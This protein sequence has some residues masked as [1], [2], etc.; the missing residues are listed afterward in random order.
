[1]DE[2]TALIAL[3]EVDMEIQRLERQL[4][5]LPQK[6][7]ILELRRKIKDIE[8]LSEKAA[9]YIEQADRVVKR[10]ED[11]TASLGARIAAEQEKATSGSVTD[12][13]ELTNIAREI[14][15]M[16]R[17]RAKKETEILE[18]LERVESGRAKAAEIDAALA[19]ARHREQQLISEFQAR[20][21]EL[22]HAIEDMRRKR[23][24]LASAI[25][26]ELLGRYEETRAAKH[27]IGLGVL[28]GTMCSVCRIDLP[29]ARLDTL[30][31]A[32][33]VATC[34]NCHRILIVRDSREA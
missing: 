10:L 24:A 25:S 4:D 34:P 32:G 11:E 9:A 22:T 7:A 8:A 16:N 33:P 28:H 6:R 19:K 29:K 13:K 20:G 2:I 31:A 17:Q 21:G 26:A 18:A 12:H 23:Q 15:A 3:A 30:R 5:E 27:G 1:M 14:D